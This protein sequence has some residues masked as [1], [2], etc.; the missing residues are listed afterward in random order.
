MAAP[1]YTLSSDSALSDDYI[2]TADVL[3]DLQSPSPVGVFNSSDQTQALFIRSDGV[4]CHI[5]PVAGA[6]A[7]GWGVSTV[8]STSG[9]TQVA[10]G[11]QADG[12]PHGF[13]TDSSNLYHIA[14]PGG[15]WTAP[16]VLPLC[17][18]LRVVN[19]IVTGELIAYGI[20]SGGNLLFIREQ[21][22]QWGA[23]S[24]AMGS[25]LVG[26]QPVLLLTD[27]S[28]DWVLAVPANAPSGGQVNIYQ[29]SPTGMTAGPMPV[30][31]QEPVA[32]VLV[33]F[34]MMNSALFLFNDTQGNLYSNVGTTAGVAQIGSKWV[35]GGAAVVD[36]TGFIHLYPID[37][38]SSLSVLHQVGWDDSTGPQWAP[39]IPLDAGFLQIFADSNP[40][41]ATAVFAVDAEGALWYSAQATDAGPWST[42][43]AQMS[44]G[45]QAYRVS[46]YR[47]QIRVVDE[48]GNP[49]ASLPI[50]VTSSAPS[51]V[52]VQGL[53]YPTS[54]TQPAVVTTDAT[55]SLTLSSVALG[56]STPAL[57]FTAQG[58]TA[59]GPINPSAPLQTYLGGAGTLN[60]G[61]SGELPAF[62]AGTLAGAS[63]GG[64]PLAPAAAQNPAV[65][66]AAA[67]GIVSMLTVGQP[68]KALSGDAAPAG[69]ILDLTDMDNPVFKTFGTADEIR[70]EE[71]AFAAA[72]S[73]D[74]WW[75]EVK[76]FFEDVWSGIKNAAIAV[77]KWVVNVV[78]ST[79]SL[80]V[81]VGDEIHNIVGQLVSGIEQVGDLVQSIFA[82]IGTEIEK[83]VDW[84]KMMFDWGD[85]WDT[86]E[87]LSAAIGGAFPYLGEQI[88][89][90]RN[91]LVNRFFAGLEQTVSTRFDEVS[92]RFASGETLSSLV[93]SG[94]AALAGG[95]GP[96][97]A[98]D[99][100]GRIISSVQ[101]NWLLEKVASNWGSG[102]SIAPVAALT[103]PMEDLGT[104][105]HTAGDDFVRAC[106]DFWDSFK[107]ALT[108]PAQFSTLGIADFLQGIKNLALA[109]LAFLDGIIDVLLDV[110]AAAVEAA[111][112]VLTTPFEIPLISAI[113]DEIAK[114]LNK[115]IPSTS[116][117]DL[118]ALALAVPITIV[119]K[120]A[121]GASSEPF[122]GGQL[123]GTDP[124]QAHY[125]VADGGAS[126]ACKYAAATVAALWALVDTGLDAI[127][128]GDAPKALGVVDIVAPALIGVLTWPGGI[129]F[130]AV[131][132]DNA[133]DKASFA[134]WIIG[135]GV[136][137]VDI[138]IFVV[139][140]VEWAEGSVLARY[141]DP[142]GKIVLSAIGTINLVSG[143]VASA[144]G[145]NAGS[146]AADVLGPLPNLLQFLRLK[147]L[148]EGSEEITLAVK[149]VADFFAGEGA[150]VAI[151]V[152]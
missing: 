52:L 73:F 68:G 84:L 7:S 18:G 119:Y 3:V 46:Q 25:S 108:D 32:A 27:A 45:A 151:A 35:Q 101:N 33:G 132:L 41:D 31:V 106:H 72:A 102:P 90:F 147:S 85:I 81:R 100:I 51:G 28:C 10:A 87:A 11:V 133:E 145:A 76:Q 4:L 54:A 5:V 36:V 12:T 109:V 6:G 55:G 146:I 65:A 60:S 141:N 126:D 114:L 20:D 47:T 130:T 38:D 123:P 67:Q 78:D 120:L 22:G 74:S 139:T 96:G 115:T 69:F 131:P 149:L 56:V 70:A 34:L 144:L 43:K 79:I 128:D 30:P 53:W 66:S 39:R 83:L 80:V 135:W 58:L 57:T 1:A 15:S 48:N 2:M 50:S 93:S 13:Y 122:P 125:P 104:A 63:V 97:S 103:Q 17:S 8:G 150:A 142:A 140:G 59:P 111:G 40:M 19:N 117:A 94:S 21:D 92:S 134:N 29:G 61:T 98:L 75:D 37:Q 91:Q 127:P 129:P 137:A 118:F 99:D 88:T 77:T 64:Q 121:K 95:P 62:A 86:K 138:A 105:F 14:G 113:V 42:G 24:L 9:V 148:E 16:D 112:Q 49:A 110:L 116:V 124:A 82:A 107:I 143:I 44:A 152:S 23:T 26:S 136:V 89:T 71:R